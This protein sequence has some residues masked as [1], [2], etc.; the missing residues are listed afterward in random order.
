MSHRLRFAVAAFKQRPAIPRTTFCAASQRCYPPP[1]PPAPAET[2]RLQNSVYL[3][4]ERL[5]DH[6]A[7]EQERGQGGGGNAELA[8][9]IQVT[10]QL[11]RG[12]GGVGARLKRRSA[13]RPSRSP[14]EALSVLLAVLLAL[15]S[16]VFILIIPPLCPLLVIIIRFLVYYAVVV[17]ASRLWS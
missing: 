3:L 7:A 11:R 10:L 12:D 15:S 9:R 14:P 1:P 2:T 4:E 8:E 5:N 16:L 13:Q 17:R 6:W